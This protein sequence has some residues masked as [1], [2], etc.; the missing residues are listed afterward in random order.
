MAARPA[1]AE[2]IDKAKRQLGMRACPA[3]ARA[4][5]IGIE[6]EL[7]LAVGTVVRMTHPSGPDPIPS[8]TWQELLSF[9][10]SVADL[11]MRIKQSKRT[12]VDAETALKA[13]GDIL[14]GHEQR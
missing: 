7:G 3:I 10:A 4:S 8:I 6:F 13:A 12:I 14:S 5:E 2:V 9:R 1:L 11:R